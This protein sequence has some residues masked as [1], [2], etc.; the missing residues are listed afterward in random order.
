MTTATSPAKHQNTTAD[1]R[2]EQSINTPSLYST[3][4]WLG[5]WDVV[6]LLPND[7]KSGPAELSQCGKQLQPAQFKQ[8]ILNTY[9][10]QIP[11][12]CITVFWGR[13]VCFL[14]KNFMLIRS[15]NTGCA[16]EFEIYFL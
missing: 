7:I 5:G 11:S 3:W 12:M 8:D 2:A 16:T 13:T 9:I 10:Y 15:Y 4:R 6:S 14:V 1:S